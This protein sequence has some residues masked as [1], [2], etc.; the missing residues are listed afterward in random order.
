MYVFS[1][2]NGDKKCV[3]SFIFA[4]NFC[5]SLLNVVFKNLGINIFEHDTIVVHIVNKKGIFSQMVARENK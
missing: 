2:Q 5:I 1:G 4:F 3:K